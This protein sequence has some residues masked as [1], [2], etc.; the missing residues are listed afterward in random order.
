MY[1]MFP[2]FR[3]ADM[4]NMYYPPDG[5]VWMFYGTKLQKLTFTSPKDERCNLKTAFVAGWFNTCEMPQQTPD[6]L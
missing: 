2:L 5:C 1:L 6:V 3:L 4:Y